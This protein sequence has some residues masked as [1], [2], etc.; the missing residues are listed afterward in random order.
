M[1]GT[2]LRD[3]SIADMAELIELEKQYLAERTQDSLDQLRERQGCIRGLRLAID[4]VK[5]RERNP[6]VDR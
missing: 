6:G 1:S 3:A 4:V 2:Q 5:N